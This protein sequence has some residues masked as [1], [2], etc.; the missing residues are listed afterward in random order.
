[1]CPA[2][3]EHDGKQYRWRKM[4]ARLERFEIGFFWQ[5]ACMFFLSWGFT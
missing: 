5:W 2:G 4:I 1:V 3:P